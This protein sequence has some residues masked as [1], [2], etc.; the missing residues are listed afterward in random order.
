MKR[1]VSIILTVLMILT[2]AA[3]GAKDSETL[4]SQSSVSTAQESA[5][6]QKELY[7]NIAFPLSDE[8]IEL[9]V[10]T[11]LLSDKKITDFNTNMQTEWYEKKTNV[12]INWIAVPSAERDTKRNLSLASGDYPD[13]YGGDF[14]IG[15]ATLYGGTVFRPL[16]ELL[17]GGY[18]PNTKAW[19][20]KEPYIL[21][22]LTAPDGKLYGFP[23]VSIGYHMRAQNKMFVKQAWLDKLGVKIPTTT[24]EFTNML[25]AFRDNDMDGDG[26]KGNEIPLLGSTSSW[27]GDPLYFLMNSFQLSNDDFLITKDNIVSFTANQDAWRSGLIYINNLYKE[28]LLAEET[29][30]QDDKQYSALVGEGIVGVATGAWQGVFCDNIAVPYTDY[31]PLLPLKGPTGLQQSPTS[32]VEGTCSVGFKGVITTS[33]K[34]PEIAAQWMDFWVSDEGTFV[35]TFGFENENFEY[36]Q[37]P[38]INGIVPSVTTYPVEKLTENSMWTNKT[39]PNQTKKDIYYLATAEEGSQNMLLYN[40]GQMYIPYEVYTGRPLTTWSSDADMEAKRSELD[41]I[42]GTYVRQA[43]AEFILGTRNIN[44][45]S[46]WDAYCKELKNLEL[47]RYVEIT[48][49]LWFGK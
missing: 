40:A 28:G 37:K 18:M 46:D 29:F 19:L 34:Y 39:V 43:T 5:P 41:T 36:N 31:V 7:G 8:K 47:D 10:W 20:E 49:V 45:D 21:K 9:T 44:S 30:V 26:K 16:N 12:H 42:I 4:S 3:C 25:V 32:S 35:S 13:I 2:L 15:Q 11:E 1:T 17:D 23:N 14:S 38:A 6:T 33:C 24:D 27:R 22:A 48:Q